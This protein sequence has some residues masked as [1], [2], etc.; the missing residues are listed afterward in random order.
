[1]WE[2]SFW[3]PAPVQ[4]ATSAPSHPLP[5]P[6][7]GSIVFLVGLTIALTLFAGPV[8]TLTRHAAEQLLDRNSY[9]LAVLGEEVAG[10]AR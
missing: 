5:V 9:L 8:S 2:E 7:I 1:V 6:M 3:K 10:A 4:S